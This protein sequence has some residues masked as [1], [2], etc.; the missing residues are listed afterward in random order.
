MSATVTAADLF[1]ANGSN[2]NFSN[3]T[4]SVSKP[5]GETVEITTEVMSGGTVRQAPTSQAGNN[6]TIELAGIGTGVPSGAHIGSIKYDFS[7]NPNDGTVITGPNQDV[8]AQT[9]SFRI[10]SI[11]GGS[12]TARWKDQ[13][14]ITAYDYKGDPITGA[15]TATAFNRAPRF[16]TEF[17]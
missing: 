3:K 12:S 16:F 1:T 14:T 7:N 11:N 15:V 2:T 9:V 5:G 4:I 17:L 10:D 8:G 13:V 6:T